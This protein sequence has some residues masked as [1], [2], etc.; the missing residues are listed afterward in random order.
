MIHVCQKVNSKLA[1]PSAGEITAFEIYC[2]KYVG[3]Q[4]STCL[5]ILKIWKNWNQ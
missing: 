3:Q 5:V 2:I 4:Q 1:I